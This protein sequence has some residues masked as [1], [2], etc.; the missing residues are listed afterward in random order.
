MHLNPRCFDTGRSDVVV[1][2]TFIFVW[3]CSSL[4]RDIFTFMSSLIYEA[5]SEII[6]TLAFY[7]E[8]NDV[9]KRNST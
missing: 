5:C 8:H 7:P 1:L 2:I 6:E 4:L 3:L 9:G